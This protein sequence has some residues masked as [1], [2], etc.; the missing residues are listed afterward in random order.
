MAL[1]GGTFTVQNKELT[2]A[3]INF[4]SAANAASALSDRGICTMPLEL[5]W[6]PEGEV[7]EVSSGDFQ[8]NCL[9]IFGYDYTDEKLKG[10]R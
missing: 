1:G 7:F 3:Y 2:G 10:L 5:D 6:G 8:K 9:E 4:V